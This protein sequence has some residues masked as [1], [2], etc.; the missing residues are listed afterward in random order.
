QTPD[1][2]VWTSEDIA[3]QFKPAT[4]SITYT[5]GP[6]VRIEDAFDMFMS[7]CRPLTDFYVPGDNRW[8][9]D[10]RAE[11]ISNFVA[12][13]WGSDY[14][15][16][17]SGTWYLSTSNS[18]IYVGATTNVWFQTDHGTFQGSYWVKGSV[19]MGWDRWTDASGQVWVALTHVNN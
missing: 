5:H 6:V 15:P 7:Y 4:Y 11:N 10:T 13:T 3:A 14:K 17:D 12:Q 18:F 8:N 1:G 16:D 9:D 19:D 2:S